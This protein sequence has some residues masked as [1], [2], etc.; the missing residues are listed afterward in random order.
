MNKII[1]AFL[2]LPL[3][4]T[5]FLCEDS[6]EVCEPPHRHK[7][8]KTFH[9]FRSERYL[10]KQISTILDQV[11][12]IAHLPF[13]T[14][15]IYVIL[16]SPIHGGWSPSRWQMSCIIYSRLTLDPTP[17]CTPSKCPWHFAHHQIPTMNFCPL[18]NA[19]LPSIH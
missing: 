3:T 17:N 14:F 7:R 10:S 12:N 18:S 13:A 16:P 6:S 9:P 2:I 4:A 8:D 11:Y 5:C 1:V 15:A 19:R